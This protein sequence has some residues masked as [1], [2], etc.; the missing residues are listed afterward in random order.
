MVDMLVMLEGGGF[1]EQFAAVLE[2]ISL[3][4]KNRKSFFS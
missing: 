4:E 1:E 3:R 2:N